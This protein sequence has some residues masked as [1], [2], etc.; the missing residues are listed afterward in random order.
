MPIIGSILTGVCALVGLACWVIVLIKMFK[1][2]Q[3][4]HGIIAIFCGIYAFIWGWMKA[5]THGL[6]KIMLIWTA[7]LILSPILLFA[8]FGASALTSIF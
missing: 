3:P 6:K 4:I 1:T 2:E 5:S 8:V 7:S